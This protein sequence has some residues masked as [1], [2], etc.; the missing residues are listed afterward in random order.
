M[1]KY[2]IFSYAQTI[3]EIDIMLTYNTTWFCQTYWNEL[4]FQFVP[5]K[6]WFG[7]WKLK[8]K[9]IMNLIPL[10]FFCPFD[11]GFDQGCVGRWVVHAGDRDHVKQ[12]VRWFL[13]LITPP[14]PVH[15][16]HSVFCSWPIL[17]CILRFCHC[18]Q[19]LIS[20]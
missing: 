4:K 16:G 13:R 20:D 15:W 2:F 1:E 14:F 11:S 19:W 9:Y 12:Q 7:V 3:F 18:L 5:F 6:T 17:C 10:F 8:S